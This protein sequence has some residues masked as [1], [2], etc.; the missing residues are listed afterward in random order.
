MQ[1]ELST[2]SDRCRTV[3]IT[4][5]QPEQ[6]AINH[7]RYVQGVRSTRTSGNMSRQERGASS[8]PRTPYPQIPGSRDSLARNPRKKR[9][10][11]DLGTQRSISTHLPVREPT[12]TPDFSLKK[13]AQKQAQFYFFPPITSTYFLISPSR[14][15][16]L[17]WLLR[18]W[19]V[20]LPP[21]TPSHDSPFSPFAFPHTPV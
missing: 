11:S 1:R 14:A 9:T 18:P 7:L 15:L 10:P 5:L 3:H 21:Y 20:V 8:R 13:T 19:Q 2:P 12:S 17:C 4:L 6:K 16:N